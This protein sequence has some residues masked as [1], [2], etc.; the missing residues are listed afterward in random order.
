MPPDVAASLLDR[1]Q[2][3]RFLAVPMPFIARMPPGL[4]GVLQR[5]E[6][7]DAHLVVERV[8]RS[9]AQ[10][11]AAAAIRGAS[12]E[13]TPPLPDGTGNRR[14]SRT[15]GCVARDPCRCPATRE[16]PLRRA[17]RHAA[18][19][20]IT[21]SLAFRY[22][23]ILKGLSPRISSRSA[24]SDNRRA[25]AAFSTDPPIIMGGDPLSP[26]LPC[27]RVHFVTRSDNC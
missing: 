6:R 16:A 10:R 11:L 12:P 5:I 24:I 17:P 3:Q 1:L 25:S 22:A 26:S 15:R 27:H 18:I 23:R 9:W 2:N 19:S 13:M 7:R 20:A 21:T 14:S 8:S 4:A